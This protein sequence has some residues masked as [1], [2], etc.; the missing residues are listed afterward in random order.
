MV[1]SLDFGIGD[2]AIDPVNLLALRIRIGEMK[3][4][5]QVVN[6]GWW[7]TSQIEEDQRGYYTALQ[8]VQR[9]NH[10][11]RE[12]AKNQV[13]TTSEMGAVVL[14]LSMKK[15]LSAL[16]RIVQVSNQT[17]QMRPPRSI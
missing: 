9:R 1:L 8:K 11:S 4:R 17:G 15:E 12:T 10:Y 6:R 7:L 16:G 5:Q 3:K 14:S 2:K 13:S